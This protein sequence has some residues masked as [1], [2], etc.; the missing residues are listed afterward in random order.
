M[1]YELLYDMY[2]PSCSKSR[3]KGPVP[4]NSLS[5]DRGGGE[6]LKNASL[7]WSQKDRSE[8]RSMETLRASHK[9]EKMWNF[10]FEN[11]VLKSYSCLC[12]WCKGQKI[13][14]SG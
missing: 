11:R 10:D 7:Q 4:Q 2:V 3:F 6:V 1:F 8:K 9:N 12:L 5:R 13:G 14:L